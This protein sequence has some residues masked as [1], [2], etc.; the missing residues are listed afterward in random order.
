M[1]DSAYSQV[2]KKNIPIKK[3]FVTNYTMYTVDS[4]KTVDVQLA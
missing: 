3:S 1:S 4:S 2:L